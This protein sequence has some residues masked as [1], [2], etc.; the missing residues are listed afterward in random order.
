MTVEEHRRGDER[1]FDPY[2]PPTPYARPHHFAVNTDPELSTRCNCENVRCSHTH[3]QDDRRCPNAASGKYRIQ[4]LGAVCKQCWSQYS[5]QYRRNT[6]PELFDLD[7]EGIALPGHVIRLLGEFAQGNGPA[8]KLY[9]AATDL[10]LVTPLDIELA[11]QELARQNE[12]LNSSPLDRLVSELR[13]IAREGEAE[14]EEERLAFALT[15][16]E[17]DGLVYIAGR[18]DS[19]RVLLDAY[20]DESGT[21]SKSAAIEAFL[22]T[23]GD[24]GD[25]GTVPLAGGTLAK[26][27]TQLW[28]EIE[29][30]S[31]DRLDQ[32]DEDEEPDEDD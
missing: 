14:Q 28:D 5:A 10:K 20:D 26:K 3:T 23:R 19:G 16:E 31:W 17:V 32:M 29:E 12:R 27:I 7:A 6:D 8:K 11:A 24:G 21:I 9:V 25:L 22:A 1:Q 4:Q 13:Q 2:V 30:E 15:D 18:Y